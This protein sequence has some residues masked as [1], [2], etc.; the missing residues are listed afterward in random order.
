VPASSA[1]AVERELK[2]AGTNDRAESSAWFF[3]TGPGQYGHGD[4]FYGV[5]VPEQRKIAKN[6]RELSLSE[7]KKLLNSKIH[8]CRLTALLIL[9]GKYEKGNEEQKSKICEFYLDNLQRVNSWDLVDTSAHK[10]LG[11]E[12]RNRDRNIL[13]KLAKSKSLWDRRVAL[14]STFAYLKDHDFKDTL[15]ICEMYLN[16]EEDLIHKAT[17]WALREVG[18]VSEPTLIKFLNKNYKRMPRTSLRYSLERLS[19]ELRQ[20]YMKK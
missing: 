7:I 4:L 15:K 12:L 20:N 9:V 1:L 2:R 16:D 6:H 19:P 11:P 13:Y 5:T 10:I 14:I 18:K 8:E 17:G 3:K